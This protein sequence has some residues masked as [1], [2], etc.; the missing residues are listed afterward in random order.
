MN[1]TN[2]MSVD[3]GF[4]DAFPLLAVLR[5]SMPFRVRRWEKAWNRARDFTRKYV[6]PAALEID[7]NMQSGHDYEIVSEFCRQAAREKMLSLVIPKVL[8]G[9]GG[10]L[11]EMC[12]IL[13]ELCAACPGLGN[14]IGAH[15]L[16]M[17]ALFG[18]LNMAMAADICE[19][20]IEGEKRGEPI[21]LSAAITEPGA[22]SDVEDEHFI[23]TAKIC[24]FAEKIE[25]GYKINGQKIFISNG[26]IAKYHAVI[27]W[28]DR[29]KP[30]ESG[31]AFIIPTGANGFNIVKSEIK[32]GQLA[33]PASVL[34]FEDC[35]VPDKNTIIPLSL[36]GG[37]FSRVN[38]VLGASRAGVAAIGTGIA[39]GAF[40]RAFEFAKNNSWRG[41]K[42]IDQQWAQFILVD[43]LK[44]I[45]VGRAL[46]IESAFNDQKH[47]LMSSLEDPLI[48]LTELFVPKIIRETAFMKKIL[49]SELITKY[50][51][52]RLES[53]ALEYRQRVQ[54]YSSA[55]KYAATDIAMENANLAIEIS[56][57]AGCA[58][59]G[60]EKTFRDAKL[61]QIYEGTNQ[62]NRMH[63]WDN[64][65]AR[66]TL[67]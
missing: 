29:N 43:M 7:R 55:A 16:G 11:I 57:A 47:G 34:V 42:L 31:I 59:H 53:I 61:V 66:N 35:F 39:R 27:L 63:I 65:I 33:C 44:N 12:I 24:T 5:G 38:F 28:Q 20:I 23:G 4:D 17:S 6:R 10:D 26:Q 15:Y 52:W 37:S 30:Y 21:L 8:G 49:R 13:E 62:I 46:Y 60:I 9:Q 50:M 56:G 1:K 2:S 41:Q 19:E 18:G 36:K 58:D 64:F 14:I 32:M 40:E 25:G 51:N 54:A 48:F 3:Y 45:M 22:G 67:C